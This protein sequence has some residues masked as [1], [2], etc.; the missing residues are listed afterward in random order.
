MELMLFDQ[1]NAVPSLHDLDDRPTDARLLQRWRQLRTEVR[2]SPARIQEDDRAIQEAMEALGLS[3]SWNSNALDSY[4]DMRFPSRQLSGQRTAGP[5]GRATAASLAEMATRRFHR[6]SRA[7]DKTDLLYEAIAANMRRARVGKGHTI[8]SCARLRDKIL[9]FDDDQGSFWDAS[10]TSFDAY[11]ARRIDRGIALTTLRADQI[12]VR[13][14]NRFI[15]DPANGF[16]E[17]IHSVTGRGPFTVCTPEN[18]L[19]HI[20]NARDGQGGRPLTDAELEQL[21]SYLEARSEAK[22]KRKELWTAW[23]DHAMFNFMLSTGARCSDIGNA[24]LR[25]LEPAFSEIS[26]YS[27][28]EHVTFFGKAMPGAGAPKQRVVPAIDLYARGWVELKRYIDH[29]RPHFVKPHTGDALFPN[30]RGDAVTANEVSSRFTEIRQKAGLCEDVRAHSL[31]HTFAQRLRNR[32][33]SRATISVLL[34][35]EDEATTKIYLKEAPEDIKAELLAHSR[36]QY[37]RT[38]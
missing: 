27:P 10:L 8:Q 36:S 6:F 34:G 15:F 31:R 19:I 33:V 4:L 32:S 37:K 9:R 3:R 29:A 23:R 11:G 35:H 2:F 7:P 16:I 22:R 12:A 26:T 30:E 17:R 13:I 21:F 1:T 25:D 14:F 5:P 18:S 24:R 28:Y 38:V 20:I